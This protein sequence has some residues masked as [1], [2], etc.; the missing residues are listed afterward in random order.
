[1]LNGMGDYLRQ[2]FYPLLLPAIVFC[3]WMHAWVNRQD[4][5]P[6]RTLPPSAAVAPLPSEPNPAVR[7]PRYTMMRG[8]DDGVASTD[9]GTP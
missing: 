7:A 8:D 2:M 6:R 4:A 1:M 9:D 3:V 5:T